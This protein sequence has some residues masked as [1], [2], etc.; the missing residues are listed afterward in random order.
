MPGRCLLGS[1]IEVP[2]DLPVRASTVPRADIPRRSSHR[3][4]RP[5]SLPACP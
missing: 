3:P 1:L 2:G 4:L 5:T